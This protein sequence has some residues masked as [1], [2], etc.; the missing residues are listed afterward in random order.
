MIKAIIISGDEQTV[1]EVSNLIKLSNPDIIIEATSQDIKNGVLTIN[2][3]QP[4]FVIID[5]FLSGGSGFDLL[6]HFER[7]DFKIL[8]ISEYSEYAIKAIDYNPIAYLLKPLI[9][10]KFTESINKAKDRILHEEKLQL[11]LFEH[12][13]GEMKSTENIIL[14]TSKQIHSVKPSD[15][16]RLEADGNY[17]TFYLVDGRKVIVSKPISEYEDVLVENDFFRIHKSHLINVRKMSYFEKAE[18]GSVVMVDGSD[19][20]V[21]S[22]K[23]DAV[24]DLLEKLG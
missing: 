6:N 11:K 12:T 4:D 10:N 20:P 5:T 9:E 13:V 17:S 15:I 8:F 14:R 7:P 23:R 19:V 3:H 18:G 21:A 16:I 1:E 22:R 24:I 2:K